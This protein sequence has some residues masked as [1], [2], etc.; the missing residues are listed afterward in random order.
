MEARDGGNKINFR[1]I[2]RETGVSV[3]TLYRV[4]NGSAGVK[5]ETRRRVTAALNRQGYLIHR[6]GPRSRLLFDFPA[7]TSS[8]DEYLH[9]YGMQLMERFASRGYHC[10]ATVHRRHPERFLDAA[11]ESGAAIFASAPE[12]GLLE[13]AKQAN[14]EL[15][16]VGLYAG[17]AADIVIGAN[18][19]E[20]G[21]IAARHLHALGHRHIA[22]HLAETHPTRGERHQGFLA[23]MKLLDPECRIDPV[24]Q[25]AGEETAAVWLRYFDAADPSPT[26]VFFLAG[27]YSQ[28]FRRDVALRFPERFAG[29]SVMS[30]DRPDTQSSLPE[31]QYE[32]DRIEF[33]PE[34][35]LDWAEYYIL[36]RPM[37]SAHSTIRTGVNVRLVV[38]G[39]V[40][41]L[42]G[43]RRA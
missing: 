23:Q 31:Y 16:T 30:Y 18:N 26:A 41:D 2:A 19:D 8:S 1:E 11:A 39:S 21:R 3:M 25:K 27:I 42:S 38:T 6:G 35:I 15:Y 9:R 36:H 14:P 17:C 29:L 40:S 37:M 22:I 5:P 12:P 13:A 4:V 7:E 20:G 43:A 10:T 28:L 33:R 32:F 24:I 34:E